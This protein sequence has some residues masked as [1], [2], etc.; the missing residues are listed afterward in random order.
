[1]AERASVESV[2][3][4]LDDMSGRLATAKNLGDVQ[5]AIGRLATTKAVI[6]LTELLTK[7]L[8][9]MKGLRA[10]MAELRESQ[11]K[12][13]RKLREEVMEA[14]DSIPEAEGGENSEETLA[15]MKE[16]VSELK[17]M[18]KALIGDDATVEV[19]RAKVR[20]FFGGGKGGGKTKP[21]AGDDE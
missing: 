19:I 14:I 4:R 18:A 12:A 7:A 1:M 10:E 16:Q 20:G 13:L 21:P 6:E 17:M 15:F 8:G 9:E 5:E 2:L 11:E 3:S